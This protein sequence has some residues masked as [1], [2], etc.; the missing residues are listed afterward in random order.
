MSGKLTAARTL[1]VKIGSSTLVDAASGTLSGDWLAAFAAD[2][3]R[4]KARGQNVVLVSSGAIALGRRHLKLAAGTLKLEEAQAAAAVGQIA[5]ARAWSEALAAHGLTVAQ[6]LL[7]L[8]DTEN[9]RRYLNARSTLKTLLSLGAVPVINENDTVAT[10]EI[11]FGDNDRLAARVTGMIEADCLVLLSDIDGLFASDPRLDANAR[12]I[13]E[14]SALT[15]EIDAMAGAA[16]SGMGS[17]GMTTKILAARIATEA[18]A[19]MVIANGALRPPLTSIEG[20]ARCTWFL[21]Q[22]T[23][24]AARKR[25]IGGSLMPAGSLTIDAGAAAALA[26]GKS[27]LPAGVTVVDGT[28]ERGDCVVVKDL[29]NREVARGLIAYGCDD[30]RRICGVKS[31]EIETILG[32]RGRSEMIHRDDMVLTRT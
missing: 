7:T 6:V 22:A 30:A 9:R 20:G 8:G 14:V 23:P 11:R 29:A 1:V 27:L 28:F 17:G 15:P 18:G 25:W 4:V 26:Q 13:S 31:G 16:G 24:A 19:N 32:Y 5:L 21:A 12:F 2:V 10:A 3:A